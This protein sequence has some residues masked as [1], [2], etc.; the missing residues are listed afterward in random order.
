MPAVQ[1]KSVRDIC[2]K[3]GSLFVRLFLGRVNVRVLQKKDQTKLRDEYNKFKDR[4]NGSKCTF[5]HH[6][7]G[8]RRVLLSRWSLHIVT[9]VR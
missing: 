4:A 1:A 7:L 9:R 3:T 6:L 2:P 8:V 5:I